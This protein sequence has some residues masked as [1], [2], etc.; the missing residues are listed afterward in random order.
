M[1]RTSWI[2]FVG[3]LALL[4]G[5][6]DSSDEQAV[7]EESPSPSPIVSPV[8]PKP[9]PPPAATA[10]QNPVQPSQPRGSA[11][12]P[13]I[14]N[15]PPPGERLNQI[16]RG[17][18]DPFALIPTQPQVVISPGTP[19]A[20]G[21][22]PTRSVPVLPRIPVAPQRAA[23][24]TAPQGV[25]R[26]RA[27][28]L[29][30]ARPGTTTA[31]R[32]GTTTAARPGTTT[33]RPGGTATRLPIPGS[34]AQGSGAALPPPFIPQLPQLPE[35]TLAKNVRVS[36][37]VQVGGV[38][39]AIVDAPN[40]SA[41]RYVRVGERLSNGQ[42]LVKRIDMNQGPTPVVILEQY[43]IE[44]ARRVGELP[45]DAPEADSPTAALNAPQLVSA[46]LSP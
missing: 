6:C 40:E 37:V 15:V 27:N 21:T 43:G 20:T 31:A 28:V 32:P 45:V 3:I 5:G 18:V 23:R 36:G 19:A 1:R 38:P 44:V 11:A 35:P 10:F 4:M 34:G 24:P 8:Q 13:G 17:R 42:V 33:A 46:N 29:P 25:S 9:S 39:S 7:V 30:T 26:A 14:L 16:P 41:S 2:A 22:A 12:A